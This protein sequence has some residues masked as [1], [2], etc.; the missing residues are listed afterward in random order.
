[1]KLRPPLRYHGGKWMLAP[2]IISHFPRHRIYVEAFGGGFSVGLRKQ[3]S[4]AEVYND[5]DDEIVGLF[6]VLR[7]D[8]CEELLSKLRLTPFA[9]GEFVEAYVE[10][11]DPVE[12]ARRLI[13]RSLMGFGSDGH[14][15][16]RPTGF[17][18]NSNRSGTTPAHDWSTYPDAL[19]NV[20]ERLAG[21]V[22]ENRHWLDICTQHDGRQTLHYL[23][24]PYLP[25]TRSGNHSSA[26]KNY[27]HEMTVKQHEELLAAIVQLKGMVILSGYPSE[28]YDTALTDWLRVERKAHA[29]GA[30]VRTEVLWISPRAAQAM[31]A[32]LLFDAA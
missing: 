28:L 22:I 21:V 24:P 3:R 27:R 32:P 2:W 7:S 11:L 20:I 4:Y 25:E 26:R 15:G 8:R 19:M 12:R 30:K 13:I 31:P 6:R 16:A 5:I 14:N 18:A 17:R 1:M 9:R 23:D 10:T 29:D